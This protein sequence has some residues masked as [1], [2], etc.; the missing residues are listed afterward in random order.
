MGV[1][2]SFAYDDL[3][4]LTTLGRGNGA[5]SIYGYDALSRLN[6][7]GHQL[8]GTSNDYSASFTYSPASQITTRTSINDGIYRWTGSN[9][10]KNYLYNDLNQMTVADGSSISHDFLS[11]GGNYRS[12][13]RYLS[14]PRSRG[15]L[16]PCGNLT[17]DGVTTYTYDSENQL[18]TVRGTPGQLDLSYDVFL[19]DGG[20]LPSLPL[21]LEA[22]RS[23]G[24]FPPLAVCVRQK[25]PAMPRPMGG[26]VYH[27]PIDGD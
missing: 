3:G 11:D 7:L 18:R 1:L 12:Y 13:P 26:T 17:G 19:S 15:D 5:D 27:F 16:P 4:R 14:S 25:S 8:S 2:A 22:P 9:G 6:S 23:R 20:C 21:L 24:S 10:V